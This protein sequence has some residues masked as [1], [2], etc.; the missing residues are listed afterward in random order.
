[1]K[2]LFQSSIIL[3]SFLGIF[4]C[5]KENID[6]NNQSGDMINV[7]ISA[8]SSLTTKSSLNDLSFSW[9]KGDHL[10]II[11][12]DTPKL[13]DF[14]LS[15][16]KDEYTSS[17]K[18]QGEIENQKGE[19]SLYGVYPAI[20]GLSNFNL[21]DKS[22]SI[23]LPQEQE[24]KYKNGLLLTESLG[25]YDYRLS[26]K[27]NINLEEINIFG[28]S[29]KSVMSILDF[30]VYNNTNALFTITKLVFRTSSEV[31]PSSANFSY[32]DNFTKTDS[33]DKTDNITVKLLSD[34][35]SGVEVG[36]GGL[37][38]VRMMLFPI[39]LSQK[40]YI[41]IY[42]EESGAS[43][44]HTLEKDVN[45]KL[46]SSGR[47]STDLILG[48]EMPEYKENG[49]FKGL[50]VKVGE[51][52]WAP[53]NSGTDFSH[54]YGLI[55]QWG[56]KVGQGYDG[57][58]TAP[59]IQEILE[60]ADRKNSLDNSFYK[61]KNDYRCQ[62]V[63]SDPEGNLAFPVTSVWCELTE[64][65]WGDKVGNPCPEGWRVPTPKELLSLKLDVK[66]DSCTWTDGKNDASSYRGIPG[67]WIGANHTSASVLNPASC[68]FLPAAGYRVFNGSASHRGDYGHYWADS[69]M[70]TYVMPQ[71]VAFHKTAIQYG[72]EKEFY[73]TA[74]GMYVRCL[75]E[76]K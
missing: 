29:F 16:S 57:E 36:K 13:A 37:I 22:I 20:S 34:N 5:Q 65:E 33:D 71:G 6:I 61:G 9:A 4:S 39:D 54:P 8:K 60:Y 64:E 43:P 41:D 75:K 55:Y 3:I 23:D 28:M 12:G 35:K 42:T 49:V 30:N 15:D 66:Y 74:Q 56:R 72:L 25:A 67:I 53:V 63:K 38:K 19:I 1:M 27:K 24:Q 44:A 76:S 32:L 52:I 45:I 69:I 47:M 50:A 11:Y 48:D 73:G 21:K 59:I 18:F 2:S 62:W 46:R 10:S 70:E 58:P 26:L 68:I 51:Y 17:E 40:I 14:T 7:S 31:I